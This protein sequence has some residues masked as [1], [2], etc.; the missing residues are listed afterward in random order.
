M[1]TEVRRL[2]D[3]ERLDELAAMIGGPGGGVAAHASAQ[4]LLERAAAFRA[5]RSPG[6]GARR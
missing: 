1:V 6:G 4:E 2:T 5:S 3:E